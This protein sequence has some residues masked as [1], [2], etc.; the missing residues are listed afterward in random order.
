MKRAYFND[1][2]DLAD[3]SVQRY[4]TGN[5]SSVSWDGESISNSTARKILP[6]SFSKFWYDFKDEKFH[7]KGLHDDVFEH[8]KDK[9]RKNL[10]DKLKKE[11]AKQSDKSAVT[12]DK[13]GKSKKYKQFTDD[14]GLV[15]FSGNQSEIV[16]KLKNNNDVWKQV[17]K[18]GPARSSSDAMKKDGVFTN[19]HILSLDKDLSNKL[20]EETRK[21]FPGYDYSDVKNEINYKAIIPD[22]KD[23]KNYSE[24][25]VDFAVQTST[26]NKIY[27][28]DDNGNTIMFNPSDI[29]IFTS[30]YPDG[31]I[32]FKDDRSP[33]LFMVGDEIKGIISPRIISEDLKED[34]KNNFSRISKGKDD[35]EKQSEKIKKSD[36]KDIFSDINLKNPD[37]TYKKK[38]SHKPINYKNIKN[39]TE[40][41][42]FK[43]LKVKNKIKEDIYK[44]AFNLN[45]DGQ[46]QGVWTDSKMIIIDK[47]ISDDIYNTNKQNRFL[48]LKE[49]NPQVEDKDV[50]DAIEEE[51]KNYGFPEWKRVV[52]D[53][54]SLSDTEASFSGEYSKGKNN[55]QENLV[56]YTDG[57]KTDMFEADYI[58][59]IKSNFPDAKMFLSKDG[60]SPAVFKVGNEIKAV[61]M[62]RNQKDFKFSNRD[63]QK[64]Q[65]SSSLLIQALEKAKKMPVG[66][67]NTKTGMKKVSEGKWVPV[68]EEKEKK[69]TSEVPEKDKKKKPEKEKVTE[70]N[71]E[72]LKNALKKMANILA[73]A[74]SGKDTVAPT[75]QAI[76][77]VGER[78][79]Q[80][81]KEA[82]K[83]KELEKQKK[84]EEK[85]SKKEEK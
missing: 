46:S 22:K 72:R 26:S 40:Q 64:M 43:E 29:N 47:N 45:S 41:K 66:T 39:E 16:K 69:S 70:D 18:M 56:K 52:P 36:P 35:F 82:D 2:Q 3:F 33:A 60:L 38:I 24:A 27:Y 7:G 79:I 54:K 8:L 75:G 42:V 74:I 13:G 55:Y 85:K 37:G 23:I 59:T 4:N 71:K 51:S 67:V 19:G 73:D 80:K 34:M 53:D 65:K 48:K 76:E 25:K 31:K 32:K 5:L 17:Q 83:K 9:L 58:A 49:R 30:K 50:K 12:S 63:F 20:G 14:D 61:L 77:D 11:E 57:T 62:P 68:S 28:S 6:D 84:N 44:P 78:N 81:K 21:K 10:D 15:Y 1:L